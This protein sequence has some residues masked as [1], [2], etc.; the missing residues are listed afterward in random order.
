MS[1]VPHGKKTS[2]LDATRELPAGIAGP[3]KGLDEALATAQKEF[4]ELK[5]ENSQLH[6]KLEEKDY[7]IDTLLQ[8]IRGCREKAEGRKHGFGSDRC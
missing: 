6:Q 5:D 7:Y 2:H 8:H 3:M 1:T 4:A